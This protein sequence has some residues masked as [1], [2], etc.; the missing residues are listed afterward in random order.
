MVRLRIPLSIAVM[1]AAFL[2]IV[3]IT[4]VA[5]DLSV[6]IREVAVSD[7]DSSGELLFRQVSQ[8]GKTVYEVRRR[9]SERLRIVAD[10][11]MFAEVK[12]D[13][14]YDVVLSGSNISFSTAVNSDG[15]I[16]R[17]LYC[18][19][20]LVYECLD[21]KVKRCSFGAQDRW[22][23]VEKRKT[24]DVIIIDGKIVGEYDC[25]PFS[26]VFARDGKRS[27]YV[28]RIEADWYVFDGVE[29][30]GPYMYAGFYE[31][32][33]DVGVSMF[34]PQ[35]SEHGQVPVFAY[36]EGNGY[37]IRAGSQIVGPFDVCP[38]SSAVYLPKDGS[39]SCSGIRAGKSVLVQGERVLF[40]GPYIKYVALDDEGQK[41]AVVAADESWTWDHTLDVESVRSG[42]P[43]PEQ[44]EKVFQACSDAVHSA[45]T[46]YIDGR[47]HATHV[48]YVAYLPDSCCFAY[49]V[50][51]SA[52]QVLGV[53]TT[54]REV[55]LIKDCMSSSFRAFSSVDRAML[56]RVLL[57]TGD[58]TIGIVKH[59]AKRFGFVEEIDEIVDS[60]Y[61]TDSERYYIIERR[62]NKVRLGFNGKWS[63]AYDAIV[64]NGSG[65]WS[66]A[67]PYA[68]GLYEPSYVWKG[69]MTLL[70]QSMSS[71]VEYVA[72]VDGKLVWCEIQE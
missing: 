32:G 11:V 13:Q 10:G 69:P 9:P 63:Q 37:F 4:E 21:E 29:R 2:F 25:A 16:V 3:S 54:G 15:G 48:S 47:I 67:A 66:N 5:A 8:D 38:T 62:G 60:W 56:S 12:G 23:V 33:K 72:F 59:T 6:C 30:Y 49:Q 36:N 19:G 50:C 20:L 52:L 35:Y 43:S 65:R 28:A 39:L 64:M 57:G 34:R 61:S 22:A 31:F 26:P 53:K 71:R 24:K 68:R 40:S 45:D 1:L 55:S 44:F 70:R 42:K 51:D 18:N 46:L 7:D 41:C 27:L 17:L 58:D 14:L